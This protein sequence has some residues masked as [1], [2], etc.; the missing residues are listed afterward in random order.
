MKVAIESQPTARTLDYAGAAAHRHRTG[1]RAQKSSG[2]INF[3]PVAWISR[4]FSYAPPSYLE[5]LKACG[6]ALETDV[7]QQRQTSCFLDKNNMT[8]HYI[9]DYMA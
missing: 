5:E 6:R 4:I 2:N 9:D 7:F 3:I 8:R 1:G